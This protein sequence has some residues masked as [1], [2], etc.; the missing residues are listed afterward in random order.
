MS[1]GTLESQQSLGCSRPT[2]NATINH[3]SRG[4]NRV[5][6]S[7][8]CGRA[9]AES[10]KLRDHRPGAGSVTKRDG[11]ELRGREPCDERAD[12]GVIQHPRRHTNHGVTRS[13]T[14]LTT[15][16]GSHGLSVMNCCDVGQMPRDR[17]T[18]VDMYAILERK[19]SVYP[20]DAGF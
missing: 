15:N 1:A 3:S 12:P 19:M 2:G 11:L 7:H 5:R 10:K 9:P 6:F 8:P 13:A 17:L 20:D 14:A 4:G 18:G 16:A